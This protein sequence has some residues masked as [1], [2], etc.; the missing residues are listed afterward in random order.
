MYLEPLKYEHHDCYTAFDIEQDRA[1]KWHRRLAHR[2]AEVAR[3]LGNM[4]VGVPANLQIDANCTTCQLVKHTNHSFPK[5]RQNQSTIPFETVQV[6]IYGPMKEGSLGG[7]YYAI[8]MVDEATC[9]EHIYF[10]NAKGEAASKI[11]EYVDDVSRSFR[12]RKVQHVVWG[13]H[14]DNAKELV[15]KEVK[16]FAAERGIK[17]TTSG[18]YCPQQNGKVERN[19]RTVNEMVTCLLY[20]ALLLEKG[21]WAEAMRFSVYI[22]NRIPTRVLGHRTPYFMAYGE[23]ADLSHLRVFGCRAYVQKKSHEI[24]KLEPKAWEGV[25]VGVHNDNPTSYRI[26]NDLN[27]K[28]TEEV[29]VTFDESVMCVKEKK[30]EDDDDDDDDDNGGND[31]DGGPV[32]APMMPGLVGAPAA[33]APIMPVL[34][35]APAAPAVDAPAVDAPAVDPVVDPPAGP[36]TRSGRPVRP[37]DMFGQWETEAHIAL[38][39]AFSTAAASNVESTVREDPPT[40]RAAMH[41]REKGLWLEAAHEEMASLNNVRAWDLEVLQPHMKVLSCKWV[42]KSKLGPDGEIA[43]RKGR[44]VVK[45][46]EQELGIDYSE[47]FAPVAMAKSIL[48]IIALAV[49]NG[50]FLFNMDVILAFLYAPVIETIYMAQPEGFE[51]FGPNG[52]K[53]VCKLNRSLYGLKQSPSNFNKKYTNVL[54]DKL[55]FTQLKADPCVFT[56]KEGD[57]IMALVLYVDD[58]MIAGNHLPM[59]DQFKQDISAEFAM[60]DLGEL[61]WMLGMEIKQDKTNGVIEVNQSVYIDQVLKRFDMTDCHPVSTPMQGYLERGPKISNGFDFEYAKLIGCLLYIAMITRPDIM[62]AVCILCRFAH[63]TT[64]AHYAAA[65]HVLKYLKGTKHLGI[66]YG[67]ANARSKLVGYDHKVFDK[68]GMQLIE[69]K[70][71]FRIQGYCD[72][73]YGADKETRRSMSAFLYELAG[74]PIVWKSTLQKTVAT[75]TAEAELVALTSA[76]KEAIHLRLM[77]SELGFPQEGPTVIWEDNQACIAM[78]VNPVHPQKSK[79]MD[80]AYFFTRERVASGEIVAMYIATEHQLADILTKPLVGHRF[81]RLRNILLGYGHLN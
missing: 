62:F 73:D 2:S 51:Q 64:A 3:R 76:A 24:R 81:K 55:Q 56:K 29:H 58:L 60:K 77:L 49:L 8:A 63:S 80:I 20:H 78:T 7:S 22:R 35:G 42:W 5:E 79:H 66:R 14:T 37:R 18:N 50:W 25:L 33:G 54:I 68:A 9:Y 38:N 19:W 12:G 59:I 11:A 75:S 65:M 28:V 27:D 23:E 67:G 43:R 16:S 21:L 47:T 13:L 32:G 10:M 36:T 72:A 52:E 15:S 48:L 41:S 40:W 26:W 34:V 44:V 74:G 53:L 70:T 31:A 57:K 6:D 4:D 30:A 61:R 45:G 46:Y 39:C 69:D 71:G 17:L 1:R